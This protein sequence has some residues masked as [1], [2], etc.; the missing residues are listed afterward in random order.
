MI[1]T[2][3]NSRVGRLSIARFLYF[4]SFD[5]PLCLMSSFNACGREVDTAATSVGV[6]QLCKGFRAKGSFLSL[7]FY[8]V[9]GLSCAVFRLR[10]SNWRRR[11]SFEYGLTELQILSVC[12]IP[13]QTASGCAIGCCLFMVEVFFAPPRA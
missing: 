3:S 10:E 7:L 8:W 1:G 5:L 12:P 6:V 11:F 13:S 2:S 9:Q 4:K